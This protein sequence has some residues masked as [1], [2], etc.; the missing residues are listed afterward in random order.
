MLAVLPLLPVLVL[1]L[2]AAPM[3]MASITPLDFVGL[4]LGSSVSVFYTV[5]PMAI[6]SRIYQRIGDRVNQPGA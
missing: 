4:V 1:L 2:R 5:L 6:A 3:S